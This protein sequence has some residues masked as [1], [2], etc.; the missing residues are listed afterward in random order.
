LYQNGKLLIQP[1][2]Y[3]KGDFSMRKDKKIYTVAT[4]H[5]D[6]TWSWPLETTVSEYLRKTI[7][8]NFDRFDKFPEYVFN[9]EGAYRYELLEEYYPE[10]F[11]KI[12]K[13]IAIGRWNVAGSEYENGDVNIPSPEAIFRNILYGNEYFFNKFGKRCKDIYLPDCFGFGQ[14]LPSIISHANLLGFTT[15]KLPWSC[16][17]GIPFDLGLWYGI[18]GEKAYAALDGRDYNYNL[19]KCRNYSPLRRKLFSNCIHYDLPMTMILH[20]IGDRGGAPRI[21][22]LETVCSD[23][24][25]N[26][27]SN[28]KIV[29]A[30]T[31]EVFMD[32]DK[33]SDIQKN[34]L[35]TWHDELISADHGIG[36]YTSRSISKRWNRRN[37]I[38]A[39]MAEKSAITASLTGVCEYPKDTLDEAWKRVIRHHFHDDIT[40]TS[41]VKCYERNWNDL[42]VSMNQFSEEYRAMV[43]G[44]SRIINT[45]F[46]K[47]TAVIVNN[48]LQFR[49]TEAV[50]I[51]F[52]C[53]EV[54]VFDA[55][56][57]EVPSQVSG[58][59]VIFLADVPPLGYKAYDV[60]DKKGNINSTDLKLENGD[61]ISIEN[62]KYKVILNADGDIGEI[63]DKELNRKI[64]SNPI[65]FDIIRY[66][67]SQSWPAWEMNYN[68]I[69]R[70]PYVKLT[71][72]EIEIVENG[73]ARITVKV[74]RS[75]AKSTFTQYI[76]LASHSESLNVY[77]EIEWRS[78]R[79][80]LKVKFP[81]EASNPKA[82][83]DLGL[84]VKQR[85]NRKRNMYEVPAQ[86]W[87]DISDVT[88]DFGVSILSDSKIGWDKPDDNALR[89][90]AIHTPRIPWRADQNMLELGLNRFG[91]AIYSHCGNPSDSRTQINA[92]C[93]NEPMTA[94]TVSK[95]SVGEHEFSLGGISSDNVIIRCIKRAENSEKIVVRLNEINGKNL[96]NVELKIGEKITEAQEVFASEEYKCPAT[97]RVGKII[98]DMKPFEVKTFLLSTE[99]KKYYSDTDEKPLELDSNTIIATSNSDRKN[100]EFSIPSELLKTSTECGNIHFNFSTEGITCA[101]QKIAMPK[102]Y[103]KLHLVMAAYSETDVDADFTVDS[104]DKRI[105]VQSAEEYIGKWDMYSSGYTGKIK[106]MPLAFMATHAHKP[107]GDIVCKELHFFKYSFDVNDEI[108]LPNDKRIIILA[109]TAV[110]NEP[111]CQVGTELYDVLESREFNYEMTPD[112]KKKSKPQRLGKFKSRFKFLLWFAKCRLRREIEQIIGI[113]RPDKY[114]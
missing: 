52:K 64:N 28:I 61:S 21:R 88:N 100:A 77:N 29:M 54:S 47:G 15:Q 4:A 12:K 113:H 30:N 16:S 53:G 108:I 85:S 14:A 9:F 86:M 57:N 104:K 105:T 69:K 76:S 67:G 82:S 92:N 17:Y 93:F 63:F 98:F 41:L 18:N 91:F 6:T 26:E 13:Y 24:R 71:N 89:L 94:F 22:D 84:G 72:P 80:L 8:E 1:F 40:G 96:K 34:K 74:T 59:S 55:D 81:L 95:N 68:E 3:S 42:C 27:K 107:D 5:L 101:S 97:I 25:N 23:F 45:N 31:D 78:L 109:A 103:N 70:E 32:M 112:E 11:E 36:C 106:R 7:D 111:T 102:G 50:S 19:K 110:R 62:S 90:T 10:E 87:A 37:E 65:C 83:F 38:L 56:G 2:L 35:P 43:A 48:P 58:N 114:N 46:V 51:D 66:E 73:A 60:R 20:G 33:L 99:V 44:I 75:A 39:D 49:R 79:S